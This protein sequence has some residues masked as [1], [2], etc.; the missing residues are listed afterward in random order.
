[1]I[2]EQ[3]N[4]KNFQEKKK[5]SV[6]NLGTTKFGNNKILNKKFCK[7]NFDFVVQKSFLTKNIFVVAEIN[8]TPGVHCTLVLL[9]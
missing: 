3:Q 6:K 5:I 7:K 9:L 4:Q 8:L 2:F 1:M